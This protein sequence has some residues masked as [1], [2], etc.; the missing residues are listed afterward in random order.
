MSD[1]L[2][3]E[4]KLFGGQ[5]KVALEGTSEDSGKEILEELYSFSRSLEKKFNFFDRRSEL[6]GLNSCRAMEVSK[7]FLEVI[8]YALD[9]CRETRG[10][11]DISLGRNILR[12]KKGEDVKDIDCS[13]E[14][15]TIDGRRVVLKNEGVMIDLGSV[16][17]G[18]IVDLMIKFLKGKGVKSGLVDARGDIYCFG[19]L[20]RKIGIQDPR[21]KNNVLGHLRL[22][23]MGIAT[24]GDFNQFDGT[25]EKCHILNQKDLILVSVVAPSL[26]E[27][28][29]YSTVLFILGLREARKFIEGR[30]D[31]K[32][33]LVD[34]DERVSYLNGFEE[35]MF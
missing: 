14:D 32:A 17:K 27:A 16:A 9:F 29:I 20:G 26:A 30:E 18:Y 15:I 19:D 12:R 11:Y 28:D 22:K 4:M 3:A 2:I 31:I 34:E 8:S 33:M 23:N 21:D 6:S 24:S 35:L 1:E 13:Y 25:Y 5:V 7:E 10:L